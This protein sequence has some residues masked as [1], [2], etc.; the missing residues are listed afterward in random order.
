MKSDD[1]GKARRMGIAIA[2][3]LTEM[4]QTI[5]PEKDAFDVAIKHYDEL[6]AAGKTEE[7]FQFALSCKDQEGL[8]VFICRLSEDILLKK[9]MPKQFR[10]VMKD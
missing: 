7:A 1:N 5:E 4:A 8:E 9:S 3:N 2:Q 10:Y 6:N